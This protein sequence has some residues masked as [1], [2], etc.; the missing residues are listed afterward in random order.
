[1]KRFLFIFI[2]FSL[3]CCSAC[4]YVYEKEFE[5]SGSDL[6]SRNG[7]DQITEEK[8]YTIQSKGLKNLHQFKEMTF[9]PTT[10]REISKIKGVYI[11]YVVLTDRDAYV[12]IVTDNSATGTKGRGNIK[13]DN[14]G[15][16]EGVYDGKYGNYYVDPRN[17]VTDTNSMY[18]IPDPKDISNKLKYRIAKKVKALNPNVSEVFISANR[19]FINHLNVYYLETIRGKKLDPYVDEFKTMVKSHFTE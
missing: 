11:S 15:T 3:L 14:S 2:L 6:G 13:K 18:T 17:V 4:S 5:K 16:S 9:S 7:M 12:A 10:A 1:M 19:D 8:N